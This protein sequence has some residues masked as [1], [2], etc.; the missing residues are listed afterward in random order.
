MSHVRAKQLAMTIQFK[1]YLLGRDVQSRRVL[2]DFFIKW[3]L[4]QGGMPEIL[5]WFQ[6][7]K[8]INDILDSKERKDRIKADA[9]WDELLL[10]HSHESEFLQIIA[11]FTA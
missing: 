11:R 4:Q 7:L 6:N 9:Y 10:A 8:E 1:E 3:T 5:A 2:L